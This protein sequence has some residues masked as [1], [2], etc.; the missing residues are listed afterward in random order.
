[1]SWLFSRALV[2][3]YSAA[4]SSGGEPCAPLNVTP[5]PRPFWRNDKT[6]DVVSRSPF[7]LTW[8]RLT[9]DRGAEL[10]TWF[11]AGFPARTSV[12]PERAQESKARKAGSGGSLPGYLAKFDP[13]TRS[14]R[15]P[16]CSL[17]GGSEEFSATWPRWGMM[18]AGECY[19]LPTPS[20]LSALR[21]VIDRH[22]TTCGNESGLSP[23]MQTP[24]SDDAVERTEGKF[25]SRGEP[26]LS[27]QVI[28]M[29]T[30]RVSSAN[31]PS[32]AEIAAGDPKRR[33][34]TAVIV[35]MPSATVQDVCGRDR[36]NQKDGSVILS[37]LGTVRRAPT[38]KASD[39]SHC[40]GG[41]R[42]SADT[43]TDWLRL[44]TPMKRDHKGPML[45][46]KGST[47]PLKDYLPNAIG[48]TCAAGGQLN[49]QWEDWFM[50]WPIG[51]T[52]ARH[53]ATDRFR[54]WLDSHGECSVTGGKQV[55]NE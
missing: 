18:R 48:E 27:A 24:V 46:K 8:R 44:P 10:L 15:T 16:Q 23:R 39:G 45:E 37:L 54:Q 2:A 20:G 36:Q 9:D 17:F 35:R 6:M 52:D 19:P 4:N 30:A 22:L 5:S 11:R 50:G 12:A 21:A 28:R 38:T 41:H 26:K 32:Q 13:A 49:P 29:P 51:W 55:T 3:A 14:W 33:L 1:M 7:G 53:S 40:S 25:N 31:G 43:L 47:E 42:G 34:E